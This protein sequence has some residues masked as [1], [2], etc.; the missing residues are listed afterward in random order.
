MS[1]ILEA[2]RK[3]EAER[4]RGQAPDLYAEL[5]PP[6][7]ARDGTG[8]GGRRWLWL[9]LALAILLAALAWWMTRAAHVRTTHVAR[10][11]SP[12]FVGEESTPATIAPLPEQTT[13]VPAK[14]VRASPRTDAQP[15][16]QAT[17]R[18]QSPP[19]A[20]RPSPEDGRAAD[21][22]SHSPA[23]AP[24]PVAASAAPLPVATSGA[25]M[26]VSELDAQSRRALPPLQL[27]MHLWDEDPAKRFVILDGQRLREGDRAGDAVIE[28]IR[29]DGVLLDWNGRKL[30][31]PLR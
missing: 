24:A 6:S 22:L 17:A 19:H 25:T 4:R 29:R 20:D 12:V 5:P 31:V 16:A 8:A 13:R 3:S 15:L 14:P 28:A 7:P 10:E 11:D 9:L 2:L 1:L 30:L 21:A 18:T 27:T 23:P 26:L